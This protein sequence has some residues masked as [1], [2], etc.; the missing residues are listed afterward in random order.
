MGVPPIG[1]D[2]RFRDQRRCWR[3]GGCSWMCSPAS[4]SRCLPAP[5]ARPPAL[6]AVAVA[7]VFGATCKVPRKRR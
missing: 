3:L 7:V 5:P 6:S 2:G 4:V 1:V